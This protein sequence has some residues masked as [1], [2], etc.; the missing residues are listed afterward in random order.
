[1]LINKQAGNINDLFMIVIENYI[2]A[3]PAIQFGN[4]ILINSFPN[5][6]EKCHHTTVLYK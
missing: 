1:M 2:K 4:E 5:I 6:I 3:N